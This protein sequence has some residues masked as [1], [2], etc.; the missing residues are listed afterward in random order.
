[1]R[2]EVSQPQSRFSALTR[3]Q[4]AVCGNNKPDQRERESE[5][6]DTAHF[7]PQLILLH[8]LPFHVITWNFFWLK[9]YKAE[10]SKMQ[11]LSFLPSCTTSIQASGLAKWMYAQRHSVFLPGCVSFTM[12]WHFVELWRITERLGKFRYSHGCFVYKCIHACF[13]VI[14]RGL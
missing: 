14:L 12:Q 1:M 6:E 2:Q 8:R 4:M 13:C 10:D 7:S 11:S 5:S 9:Q 3:Q